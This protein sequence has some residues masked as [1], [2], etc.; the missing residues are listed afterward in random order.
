MAKKTIIILFA[1]FFSLAVNAQGNLEKVYDEK[2][3][4]M[5]QIDN[6]LAKAKAENKFVVCQ[7][8][9]NWCPWCLRF[10]DFITSDS[11]IYKIVKDNFIYIHVNY[12]PRTQADKSSKTAAL[13]KR[14]GSPSRFGFPVL[15]VLNGSGNVIHIQDS[16]FLEEGS[17]YN[18]DKVMRFFRCWTPEA[19]KGL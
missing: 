3:D 12:N 18:K 1:A 4:P 15:V 19:V 8:G 2:I 6:A 14:L 11:D 10:A 13:L 7:L 16:S 9:G 5:T 17:G